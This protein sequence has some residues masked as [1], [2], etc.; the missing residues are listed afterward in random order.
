MYGSQN[1]DARVFEL[2]KSLAGLKQG[3]QSFVQHLGSLKSM[4]NELDLYRPHTT[5]SA[6]LLKR[7]DE[8]KVFQLLASLGDEYEDLRSHLLMTPELPSFINVCH[9]VQREETRRKVMHIEPKFSSEA[10][11]FTSNHKISGERVFNG[12][13]V[14]WKCTYCNIKGHLWEKCWILHP[15]LKPKFDKEGKMIKV[16]KKFSPKAFRETSCSADEMVNFTSNLISL[17]NEF[18]TFLQRKNRTAK[19]ENMITEN[20]TTMLGKFAGFLAGSDTTTHGNIPG[21]VSALSIALNAH[22]THDFWIVDSGATDHIANKTSCLHEFQKLNDPTHVSIANGKGEPVLGKGKIRLMGNDV[23]SIAFYVPS[24]PFQLLSIG[25]ITH[26]L[27]C[28]AIFYPHNVVFQDR[29]TQKKIGEGFFLNGLYYLSKKFNLV[30]DP[31]ANLSHAQEYQLWYQRLAHPSEPVMSKL[32]PN[33]CKSTHECETCQMSKSTRLSFVSSQSRTSK[34][35]E[36]T[37]SDIWGLSHVESFN[38]YKYY[39]T[40]IDDYSLGLP[41]CIF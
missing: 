20:S 19:N 31:I 18:A 25:K 26:T 4:W 34:L 14:D 33:F 13:K 41:G 40:F 39:V 5:E 7:V 24:F 22:L 12:K 32:F 11:V 8:D 28:L 30:T 16:G 36:V 9:A 35:F 15:E 17:I 2:K 6:V 23:E 10:R 37:H 29:V 1:N 38:G 3:D 27:D 21:I